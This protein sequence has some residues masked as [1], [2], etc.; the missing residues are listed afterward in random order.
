MKA[1]ASIQI[2]VRE[3]IKTPDGASNIPVD[4]LISSENSFALK[5]RLPNLNPPNAS[6]YKHLG[7]QATFPS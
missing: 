4:A 3:G 6:T 2:C 7:S 5:Y 1:S